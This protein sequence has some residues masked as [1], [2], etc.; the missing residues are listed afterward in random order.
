M[1]EN[2]AFAITATSQRDQWVKPLDVEIGTFQENH[3][4]AM[5]AD[6]LTAVEA[7][8]PYVAS[9]SATTVLAIQYRQVLIFYGEWCKLPAPYLCW[10]IEQNSNTLYVFL[11]KYLARRGLF[12]V[13]DLLIEVHGTPIRID[14]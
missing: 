13:V 11:K 5:T 14:G 6:E 12:L 7:Q 4:N 9:P 3:A 1:F 2:S 8:A 10:E